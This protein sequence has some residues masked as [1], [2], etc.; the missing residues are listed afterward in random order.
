MNLKQRL[1]Y[2]RKQEDEREQRRNEENKKTRN[3]KLVGYLR[4]LEKV[5]Y[6]RVPGTKL[7]LKLTYA[8]TNDAWT[9]D[10]YYCDDL[11]QNMCTNMEH[12]EF[13]TQ[14]LKDQKHCWKCNRRV[15][16]EDLALRCSFDEFF[17]SHLD[18]LNVWYRALAEKE[19]ERKESGEPVALHITADGITDIVPWNPNLKRDLQ[20]V[21]YWISAL[22]RAVFPYE[23]DEGYDHVELCVLAAD[24]ELQ[25]LNPLLVFVKAA[26]L[27]RMN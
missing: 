3:D 19:H 12:M 1:A 6:V 5:I 20:Q 10:T 24:E 13:H 9:V 23:D 8:E 14:S 27:L 18:M 16:G 15:H 26:L 2:I 4:N 25:A 17:D 22:S 11:V 21:T 7:Q